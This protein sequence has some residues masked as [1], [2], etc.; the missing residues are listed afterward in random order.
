VLP[1]NGVAR[2]TLEAI[3]KAILHGIRRE[4]AKVAGA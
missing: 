2:S 3:V 4:R 1:A